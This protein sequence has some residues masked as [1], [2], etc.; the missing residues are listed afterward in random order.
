[1]DPKRAIVVPKA[2]VGNHYLGKAVA[3]VEIYFWCIFKQDCFVYKIGF[4]Q[5]YYKH[6]IRRAIASLLIYY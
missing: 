6:I 1:M 5:S 2:V 3:Q 4:F